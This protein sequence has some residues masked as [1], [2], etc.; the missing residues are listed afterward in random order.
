LTDSCDIKQ[1]EWFLGLYNIPGIALILQAIP[2]GIPILQDRL[3]TEAILEYL[4]PE[5]IRSAVLGIDRDTESYDSSMPKQ[6]AEF[7]K[8]YRSCGTVMLPYQSQKVELWIR[9]D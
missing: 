6:L 5:K 8:A 9:S 7:P 4:S 3:S 2:I 1:S